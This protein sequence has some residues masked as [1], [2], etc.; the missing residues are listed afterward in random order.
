MFP[1][2]PSEDIKKI[3]E[4]LNF[5]GINGENCEEKRYSGWARSIGHQ[6]LSN[7]PCYYLYKQNQ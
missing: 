4:F 2:D 6:A 3:S 7:K 1:F 5:R